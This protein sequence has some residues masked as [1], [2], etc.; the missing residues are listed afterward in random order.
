[1]TLLIAAVALFTVA[2]LTVVILASSGP[3]PITS[4]P[5]EDAFRERRCRPCRPPGFD[6]LASIVKQDRR[7]RATQ[8]TAS[9]SRALLAEAFLASEYGRPAALESEEW[10]DELATTAKPHEVP[11]DLQAARVLYRVARGDR[12]SGVT[13]ARATGLVESPRRWPGSP[14]RAC[15]RAVEITGARW[16]I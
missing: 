16:R 4:L 11:E 6:E 1:V 12:Q 2:A 8:P 10:A 13:V 14:G 5:R 7:I 3:L 15:S 9:V